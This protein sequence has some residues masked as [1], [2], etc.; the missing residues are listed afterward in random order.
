MKNEV[1]KLLERHELLVHSEMKRVVSHVQRQTTS[2]IINTV[3][4]ADCSTPFRFKRKK[5]YRD[6]K[7]AYVNMTYYPST[8]TIGGIDIEVMNVVRIRIA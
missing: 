5:R 1:D 6:L 2:W 4:L 8:E 3:M 7:G